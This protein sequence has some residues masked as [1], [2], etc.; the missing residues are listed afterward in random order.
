MKLVQ[1]TV[2]GGMATR[3]LV[4]G[5]AFS[6]AALCA[7][8]HTGPFCDWYSP[9]G[10]TTPTGWTSWTE[11]TNYWREVSG[12]ENGFRF[13]RPGDCVRLTSSGR[14]GKVFMEDGVSVT[15][16]VGLVVGLN[17]ACQAS[18]E[19]RQGSYVNVRTS[20]PGQ[21]FEGVWVGWSPQNCRGNLRVCGTLDTM[22]LT[23]GNSDTSSGTLI[24]EPSGIVSN[25]AYNT[26]VG[27][28]Q[29]SG[30]MIVNGG[31]F[32]TKLTTSDLTLGGV[33]GEVSVVS[34]G[35][36]SAG[37]V[38]L[39]GD[40][41]IRVCDSEMKVFGGDWAQDSARF[42]FAGAADKVSG[43]FFTNALLNINS[44]DRNATPMQ[45]VQFRSLGVS[46]FV[47][48][49]SVV[50]NHGVWFRPNDNAGNLLPAVPPRYEIDGGELYII[51]SNSQGEI[52]DGH[53]N[54]SASSG[55]CAFT[56]APMSFTV[57]L[58][59]AAKVSTPWINTNVLV[60]GQH[61]VDK[62]RKYAITENRPHFEFVLSRDGHAPYV[63]R[64]QS[65]VMGMYSVW[66][67]GGVQVISATRLPLVRHSSAS[68][69]LYTMD[70]PQ[71]RAPNTNLWET[72]TFADVPREWGVTLKQSAEVASGAD[73]GAGVASGYIRLPKHNAARLRRAVVRMKISP[74]TKTLSEVVAG[75]CAAGYDAA[76]ASEDG[77]NVVVSLL[78]EEPLISRASDNVMVFDFTARQDS[79]AVRD[80]VATAEALVQAADVVVEGPGL[81]LTFH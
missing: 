45:R 76:E 13:P 19:L 46:R 74:Q 4:V 72:G 53:N 48:S 71:F 1:K 39:N 44:S 49:H 32:I 80:R 30:T 73:L 17:N 65:G 27:Y 5:F 69:T 55:I 37:R 50:T 52:K 43:A 63:I 51:E 29:G 21:N 60:T 26:R 59:G 81:I 14:T 64:R 28:N 25:V 22:Q 16:L 47:Q 18:L 11:T 2:V 41:V 23:V 42:N 6:L 79:I 56:N 68:A 40:S 34:N 8:A 3:R 57:S 24:I 10:G 54:G 15:G 36:L 67:E 9:W 77:Y 20:N 78:G 7:A 66:P 31:R 12:T 58:R 75:M 70:E 62:V 38:M 33:K 35:F 61:L